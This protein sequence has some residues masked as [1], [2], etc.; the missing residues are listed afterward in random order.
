MLKKLLFAIA[1]LA[2]MVA[3]V[4]ADDNELSFDLTSISDASIEIEDV[5]LDN[6]DVDQLGAQAEGEGNEAA[7]EAC[8]RRF[9][10]RYG[11]CGYT[12]WYRPCY[13]YGYNY[14]SY[15]SFY[16]YRPIY[17]YAVAP[18]YNHYWGCY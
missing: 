3:T 18:I 15:P 17:R 13:S 1:P 4:S 11:G 7:I 10:Y 6:L 5:G 8:F 9:G 12:R 2:L 16:C 14:C